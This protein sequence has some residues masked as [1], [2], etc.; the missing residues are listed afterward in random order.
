MNAFFKEK[1]KKDCC[2]SVQTTILLTYTHWPRTN[3]HSC[4]M[5]SRKHMWGGQKDPR[6]FS[7]E[8]GTH[9]YSEFATLC[10]SLRVSC[11]EWNKDWLR[12]S[13]IYKSHVVVF[14]VLLLVFMHLGLVPFALSDCALIPPPPL[15]PYCPCLPHFALWG[16]KTTNRPQIPPPSFP[17][18][19]PVVCPS[20]A[21]K[22]EGKKIVPC[23]V[24]QSA[25]CPS[26]T[27]ED[28]PFL[29]IAYG[30]GLRVLDNKIWKQTFP[31]PQGRTI[32]REGPP[33]IPPPPPPLPLL[34]TKA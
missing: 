21:V 13:Y 7:S 10:S 26:A 4:G 22:V 17:S 32:K 27:Q 20:V 12:L 29:F 9:P 16:P 14:A 19:F 31:P 18:E 3:A 8:T 2:A 24:K 23:A 15:S 5:A 6:P 25:K 28:R 1:E 11:V 33:L 30:G 34:P